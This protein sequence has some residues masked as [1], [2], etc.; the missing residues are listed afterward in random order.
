MVMGAC[1]VTALWP[2]AWVIMFGVSCWILG[3]RVIK[4]IDPAGGVPSIYGILPTAVGSVVF[5][6]CVELTA[7]LRVHYPIVHFACVALPIVIWRRDCRRLG[8]AAIES[9]RQE[10]GRVLSAQLCQSL[11]GGLALAFMFIA[12]L[13]EAG[14]DALAMHLVIPDE[15]ASSA[16]WHFDYMHQAWALMPKQA[17]WLYS[18]AF[19]HGGE[20]G[21]K[22]MNVGWIIGLGLAV[23]W[24]SQQGV[25]RPVASAGPLAAAVFL[26]IP[27]VAGQASTLP[28]DSIMALYVCLGFALFAT[29][30]DRFASGPRLLATCMMFSAAV[31]TKPQALVIT[32]ALGIVMIWWIVG[33]LTR[34]RS[35]GWLALFSVVS[36]VAAAPYLRAWY[37]T[38][39]PM[40]PF[41]N[42]IFRSTG[43]PFRNFEDARWHASIDWTLLYQLQF[44]TQRFGEGGRGSAGFQW[45]LLV[46]CCAVAA[47]GVRS[48]LGTRLLLGAIVSF[49]SVF[50]FM[51]YIRYTLPSIVLLAPIFGIGM[52]VSASALARMIS[53]AATCCIVL[54]SAFWGGALAV[55]WRTMLQ[56]FAH[57]NL[58]A[59]D[60]ASELPI[61]WAVQT[62]NLLNQDRTPVA[63]FSAPCSA[64][65]RAV[66][67]QP[68][69]YCSDFEEA[70]SSATGPEKLAGV[71]CLRRVEF[72]IVQ[73]DWV[74]PD[75]R[76]SLEA[77]TDLVAQKGPVQV[78]K[79]KA[80]MCD[81]AASPETMSSG[82]G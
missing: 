70:V 8:E 29:D 2:I 6:A 82:T 71:L 5:G 80:S 38:G 33:G 21:A 61:R 26:S 36:L 64:F 60:A 10:P 57:P 79:V 58:Q 32:G 43:F 49:A 54:N 41:Y 81:P 35:T 55:S 20:L 39:N 16:R 14:Q 52:S 28:T 15:V 62:V 4:A 3:N 40:F 31:A 68:L 37:M 53:V 76:A 9:V 18:V 63:F 17:H 48:K 75:Q 65:L 73:D 23:C 7:G 74:S 1:F 66:P 25:L 47:L 51:S 19:M 30:P 13:P 11:F 46:P 78:R 44:E 24:M 42:A 77:I 34:L 56:V 45:L 69:W 67:L 22:L 72:L 27:L 59:S 12:V 50:V